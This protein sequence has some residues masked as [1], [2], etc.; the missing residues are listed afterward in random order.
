MSAS[1]SIR[2]LSKRFGGVVV[3][4][5]LDLDAPSGSLTAVIGPNG[6]GKTTLFNLISGT[7]RP[8]AGRILLDDAELVGRS[9]LA[10]VSAG[11]GRAF[12][13]ANLFPT[14]TVREAIAG[15][16][17]AK[18]ARLSRP[19]SSFPDAEL[20]ARADEI[21]ALV[22]LTRVADRVGSTLSHGDQ[23][24]LD[25]ALALA[26]DPRLLLLDEPMAGMG[27]EERVGMTDCIR[28]LWSQG[29]M[30]VVFIE[31]DMDVV[32]AL[33]ERV[34]VLQQGAKIAMGTPDEIRRHPDVI[35]AYLGNDFE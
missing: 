30:T 19:W 31:H 27:H 2:G 21:A 9:P 25:I 15:S 20:L 12:Q 26:L 3:T 32:F 1:L 23:K 6:A 24:L 7:L 5:E 14:F 16:V 22:G 8:D 10:I 33:A 11:V 13:V 18:R 4:K 17:G 35:K 28:R 34:C 29:G